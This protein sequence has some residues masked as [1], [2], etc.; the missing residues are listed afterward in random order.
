MEVYKNCNFNKKADFVSVVFAQY[1]WVI[2]SD[3]SVFVYCKFGL[4]QSSSMF[5]W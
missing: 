5:A 4:T 2:S 1:V 3:F